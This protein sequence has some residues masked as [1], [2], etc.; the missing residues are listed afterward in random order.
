M[1]PERP[2]APCGCGGEPRGLICGFGN[3]QIECTKC[4]LQTRQH[5]G[6]ENAKAAWNRALSR[7]GADREAELVDVLV[8]RDFIKFWH[9][10]FVLGH[11]SYYGM[12]DTRLKKMGTSLDAVLARAA[13]SHQ[14]QDDH[15]L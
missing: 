8:D 7:A 1:T 11:K 13:L 3:F 12:L 2:L 10:Y 14:E 9:D 4:E 5:Q 15:A 6:L